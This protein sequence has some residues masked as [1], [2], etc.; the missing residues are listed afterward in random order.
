MLQDLLAPLTFDIFGD[1]A[2]IPPLEIDNSPVEIP[3]HGDRD[4]GRL[5]HGMPRL[6]FSWLPSVGPLL[7]RPALFPLLACSDAAK[8]RPVERPSG[9]I[10]VSDTSVLMQEIRAFREGLRGDLLHMFG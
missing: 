10:V 1:D 8:P 3:D 4:S 9:I 2:E 5:P 6:P 7:P